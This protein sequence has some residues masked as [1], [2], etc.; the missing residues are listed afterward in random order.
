VEGVALRMNAIEFLKWWRDNKRLPGCA[1]LT[2]NAEL[3]R[4]LQ[5]G[6]VSINGL[7]LGPGD[8]VGF[9]VHRLVFFEGARSQTTMIWDA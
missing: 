1:R 4:W 2:S 3:R 8:E 6:S 9:P 7:R 5:K